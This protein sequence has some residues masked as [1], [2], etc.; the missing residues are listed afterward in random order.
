[1]SIGIPE[2]IILLILFVFLAVLI[3][4]IILLLRWLG[5]RSAMNRRVDALEREVQSLR[6]QRTPE[7]VR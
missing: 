6:D 3:G 4:G 2:L 5:G 7:D 1:M